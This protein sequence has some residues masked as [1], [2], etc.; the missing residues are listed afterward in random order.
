MRFQSNA[1]SCGPASIRNALLCLGVTRSEEELERL[2]GFTAASGTSIQGIVKALR[3]IAGEN[4]VLS[5]EVL[6]ESRAQVAILRLS[7]AL[8]RGRPAIICVDN[9]THWVSAVG[10][11]GQDIYHIADP[12]DPE[13]ILSINVAQLAQRWKGAGRQPYQG[14]IV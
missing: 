3:T 1:S 11:L 5:P 14:V 9:D 2:A 4:P 7:N 8:Y 13:L 10:N 12:A 6:R